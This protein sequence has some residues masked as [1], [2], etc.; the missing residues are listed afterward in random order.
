MEL[1]KVR[2][3]DVADGPAPGRSTF[4]SKWREAANGPWRVAEAGEG[5]PCGSR[6]QVQAR[7]RPG[8][9]SLCRMENPPELGTTYENRAFSTP[10][11]GP[12]NR[13][14]TVYVSEPPA[15]TRKASPSRSTRT[16]RFGSG[17]G[18]TPSPTSTT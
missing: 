18:S 1:G 12:G 8:G 15:V 10:D 6:P 13:S 17:P 14:P 4:P 2:S 7:Q 11:T 9:S 3:A 5:R 16:A